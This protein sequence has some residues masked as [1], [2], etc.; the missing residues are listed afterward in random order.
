MWALDAAMGAVRWS[1]EVGLAITAPPALAADV[2]YVPTA[3][4]V[5]VVS[6]VDGSE[7]WTTVGV[8]NVTAQ[9]AVAAPS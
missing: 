1:S 2:L 5:V 3:G 4:G 9:P 8:G 7:L 6:A